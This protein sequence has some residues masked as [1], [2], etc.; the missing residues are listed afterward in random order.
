MR[1][2]ILLVCVLL[3]VS[4]T[5]VA[6]QTTQSA[7]QP[8]NERWCI[9]LVDF[10]DTETRLNLQGEVRDLV[11]DG[12]IAYPATVQRCVRTMAYCLGELKAWRWPK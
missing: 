6:A 5:P 9:G 2:A 10:V 11:H 7:A 12:C 1:S 3:A 4:A 8:T